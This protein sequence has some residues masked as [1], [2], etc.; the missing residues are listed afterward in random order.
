[1]SEFELEQWKYVRDNWTRLSKVQRMKILY[2][3]EA[4]KFM[5]DDREP[6]LT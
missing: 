2:M 3:V 6:V 1:M 5:L 4:M